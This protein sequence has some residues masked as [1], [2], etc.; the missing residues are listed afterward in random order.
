MRRKR[1][2]TETG[3]KRFANLRDDSRGRYAFLA[4]STENALPSIVYDRFT[5]VDLGRITAEY[6]DLLCSDRELQELVA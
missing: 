4:A 1:L 2:N 6:D 5:I 3:R